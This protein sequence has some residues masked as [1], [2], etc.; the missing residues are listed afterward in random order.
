MNQ[1]WLRNALNVKDNAYETL[2]FAYSRK[3][4]LFVL[5]SNITISNVE[6]ESSPPYLEDAMTDSKK[7]Q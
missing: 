1:K 6:K 7:R 3:L 4:D 2:I 5:A